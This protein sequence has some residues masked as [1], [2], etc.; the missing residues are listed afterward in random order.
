MFTNKSLLEYHL[1]P[2]EKGFVFQ[3]VEQS[4]IVTNYVKRVGV[5]HAGNNW[6][7]AIDK[8]PEIDVINKVIYLQGRKSKKDGIM[9]RNMNVASNK[10]IKK[11]IGAINKALQDLCSDAKGNRSRNPFKYY[12]TFVI[13]LREL[14]YFAPFRKSKDNRILVI[15]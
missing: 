1:D 13:D 15:R 12:D 6:K 7:V 8:E 10:E 11:L 2:Y 14:D 4:D 3:I 9:H 5:Y